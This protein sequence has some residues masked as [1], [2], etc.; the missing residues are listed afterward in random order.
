M[1]SGQQKKVAIIGLGQV[2]GSLGKALKLK[3]DKYFVIGI[4]KDASVLKTAL[5]IAAADKTSLSPEAAKD[6][7]IVVIC[8][9]ADTIARIYKSL[10]NIAKA[11]AVITD[12]GSVKESVERQ[13]T[14]G[15]RSTKRRNAFSLRLPF[16]GS[17]PMAGKEKN[18]I[19]SADAYMYKDAKVVIINSDKRLLKY[20]R[21]VANLWKDAGSKIVKMRAKEHDGLVALTS[22]LPHIIAF[23][24]NK[25]YKRTQN[26]NPNAGALAAG[27]FKS[28]TRV[29]VSSADMWAPIFQMNSKNVGKYL[30]AFIKEMRIFEKSLSDKKKLKQKILETQR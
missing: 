11:G 17:H 30:K 15:G 4:D 23:A 12:A 6:A 9:P 29:A 1:N 13:I 14:G 16:I 24:L 19:M 5:K 8:T 21:Q 20:E 3:P 26:K 10:S 18:G 2:G 25:I 22:H 28:M 7:D 27:S